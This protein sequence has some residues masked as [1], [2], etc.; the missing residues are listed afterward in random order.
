MQKVSS[1]VIA[2]LF[3]LALI[4]FQPQMGKS[5]HSMPFAGTVRLGPTSQNKIAIYASADSVTFTVPVATSADVPSSATAT[6]DFI[7]LSNPM[8]IGYTVSPGRRR[9]LPL[10]GGGVSTEFTFTITTNTGNTKT[11]MIGSQFVLVSATNATT[12]APLTR[13]INITVQ[14]QIAE[15][16]GDG[17]NDP[18]SGVFCDPIGPPSGDPLMSVC[19]Y[20]PIVVDT[21]GN[22]FDLTD[23][24]GGVRFDLNGDGI[25]AR[26]SW[27]AAGS[28]DAWLV[29]D[30]DGNEAIDN[31][32]ELFGNFTQQPQSSSPNGFLAL[33]EYDKPDNGG[34][35]DG[36]IDS[37]D[38]IFSSLR[39]W[40]DINHDAISDP[41]ELHSLSEFVITSI[42]LDYKESRRRDRHGNLFRYRAKIHG[43]AGERPG[44]WAYDVF[45]QR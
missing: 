19:C 13:D 25:P 11:G 9:E 39:L 33:A 36:L 44:R 43:A 37:R 29:L 21:L 23:V 24:A 4:S 1:R 32:K 41:E 26:T 8:N 14:S 27:T 17:S 12:T 28:D 5:V 31:G 15:N 40:R 3:I 2:V 45:L 10:A 35:A 7:E 38:R 42:S 18:C 34:N 16:P 20:T 30:R 6:V 22:G